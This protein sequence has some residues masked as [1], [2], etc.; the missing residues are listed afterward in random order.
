M[1]YDN[2]CKKCQHYDFN[3]QKGILCRIT[4][5]KPDFDQVCMQFQL[6]PNREAEIQKSKDLKEIRNKQVPVEMDERLKKW[7][8]GLIIL[9]VIHILASQFLDPVWGGIIIILGILNLVIKKRGMF[10]ANGIALLLVGLLN[11]LSG[12]LDNPVNF[13]WGVF[14]I[15]QLIWGIQEIRKYKLYDNDQKTEND[16]SIG[17]SQTTSWPVT[18]TFPKKHKHSGFGIA[19]FS[20]A[21]IALIVLVLL[22]ITSVYLNIVNPDGIDEESPEAILLGL[23]MILDLFMVLIGTGLGIAGVVGNGKKKVFSVLGLVFNGVFLILLVLAFIP[24]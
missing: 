18:E 15:V 12:F 20:I 23:I 6:D 21:S 24:E 2:F 13:F 9:G 17:K 3:L 22:F 5:A 10:V 8:I 14:G 4:N 19:S 1:D 16:K 7:G 11:I